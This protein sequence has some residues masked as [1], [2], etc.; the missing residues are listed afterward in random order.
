MAKIKPHDLIPLKSY[1]QFFLSDSLYNQLF[2]SYNFKYAPQ[3]PTKDIIKLTTQIKTYFNSSFIMFLKS[4]YF[5]IMSDI[6]PIKP[7]KKATPPPIISN[8]IILH[9]LWLSKL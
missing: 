8:K 5:F 2:L 4:I 1:N 9:E 7:A 6:I 3:K